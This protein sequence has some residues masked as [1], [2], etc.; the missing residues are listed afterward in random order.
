M[1]KLTKLAALF[2]AGSLIFGGLFL[3]CDDGDSG[4]NDPVLSKVIAGGTAE[5]VNGEKFAA[6]KL[7]YAYYD[8]ATVGT[9]S[10]PG[11]SAKD[12]T[13][14]ATFK[15]GSTE[16]KVGDVV[17]LDAGTYTLTVT[18][19][20]KTA[21]GT[22]DL[23]VTASDNGG[24]DDQVYSL[25]LDSTEITITAK[26][27]STFTGTVA[28]GE[29]TITVMEGT[30]TVSGTTIT[31]T[32]TKELNDAGT[33]L[34]TLSAPYTMTLSIG[35]SN[36][37]TIVDAVGDEALNFTANFKALTGGTAVSADSY[38]GNAD[39]TPAL[40]LDLTTFPTDDVPLIINASAKNGMRLRAGTN[41]INYNGGTTAAFAKT[42]VGETLSETLDRYVAL[43]VSKLA[44]SGNVTVTFT[45]ITKM[46][47]KKTAYLGQAVLVDQSNKIL[48]SVTNLKIDQ[49]GTAEGV[50]EFSLSATIDA[51][52]VTKVI[53]GFSRGGVG[54]GGIDVTGITAVS[55]E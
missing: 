31:A 2:A 19:G 17:S 49:T 18:F 52:A 54:G 32:V 51:S 41:N 4:N 39:K 33:A 20:G 15:T 7:V 22:V 9:F 34:E 44:T 45:G 38:I 11:T 24:S 29:S 8:N 40:N 35:D 42:A 50:E 1:K 23:T 14:K 26:A 30:Y 53:L 37:L 28:A 27:D 47:D 12:V 46:S 55:A 5:V 25:T 16:F 10:D 13:A 48:A 3:S 6:E 36:V 43:D 21:E